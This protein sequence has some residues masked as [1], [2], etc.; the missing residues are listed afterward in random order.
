M[1]EAISE[2]PEFVEHIVQEMS[3]KFYT[4]DAWLRFTRLTE[5]LPFDFPREYGNFKGMGVKGLALAKCILG[6][7]LWLVGGTNNVIRKFTL[8]YCLEQQEHSSQ[9]SATLDS[10]GE[11][12]NRLVY[13]Y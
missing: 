12:L 10:R 2:I 4:F 7:G 1:I 6:F 9:E 5:K 3:F 13:F 8:T 11:G